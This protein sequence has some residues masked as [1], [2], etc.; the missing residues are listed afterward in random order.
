[1]NKKS[2]PGRTSNRADKK[3]SLLNFSRKIMK[4]Q[5]RDKK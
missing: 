2:A 1:M 3:I 5:G 4:S